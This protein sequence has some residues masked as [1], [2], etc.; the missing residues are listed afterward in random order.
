MLNIKA[1]V[2]N[3]GRKRILIVDGDIKIQSILRTC[4]THAGYKVE[5]ANTGEEAMACLRVKPPQLVLIDSNTP[6]V[7]GFEIIRYMRGTKA[8]KSIPV[9][10]LT[11]ESE[12][13]LIE[14]ALNSGARRYLVKPI[15][16]HLLIDRIKKEFG[17][18]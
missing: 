7:D 18:K 15:D 1:Y 12:L 8:L 16:P 6:G 13:E 14:R 10:V 3:C 2:T 5:C 11:T 17:R 4:L 9:F